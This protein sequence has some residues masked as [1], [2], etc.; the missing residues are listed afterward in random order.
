MAACLAEGR[1][2]LENAAMEPEITDLAEM[3]IRMGA[4]ITGH[5]TSRIVIDGVE[6]LHGCEHQ[7]V[8]DRIEA[9]TF[10][11]A[12][13]ATRGRGLFAQCPRADHLGAVIDKLQEAGAQVLAEEGGVRI[14]SEGPLKAQSFAPPNTPV[15]PP[16]CRRSSWP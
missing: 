13:A 4:R 10:L 1:T 12:V 6:Q 3:L 9:G 7:V 14:R 8:A 15:F 16:T 5:G 2:V 11:C